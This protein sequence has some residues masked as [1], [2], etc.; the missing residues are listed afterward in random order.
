MKIN[1]NQIDLA[2][3][4]P[5]V[6]Q[7]TSGTAFSGNFGS[8][9]TNGGYMGPNVVWTSGGQ[10]IISG[11][12]TFDSSPRVPYSG[13][14][15][16]APSTLLVLDLISN[17]SGWATGAYS[18]AGL[19]GASGV[20]ATTIF[21]TGAALSKV[22]VTGS[23][24]IQA[25]N[26]TGLGGTLIFQ[27]G[28][29]VFI[30]GGAG[31][32]GGGSV[33]VTGSSAISSA[34]FTGVGSTSVTYNGT[35]VLI[36]GAAGADATLSG[37]VEN[38]FV[39]R[40]AIDESISGFKIFTGNPWVPAPTALSGVVNLAYLT[41]VSGVLVS[42]AGSI[43]NTYYITGTGVVSI[44]ASGTTINNTISVTSGNI[45][46]TNTGTNVTTSMTVTNGTIN[47]NIY[48]NSLTGNFVNMSWFFD[49]YSLATGLNQL[50][51]FVG[52]TFIFTG[53]AIGVINTGT[54][55]SFSGSFYQRNTINAKTN[56]VSFGLPIGQIFSGRGGFSQ[57][58]TGMNR[59]G[60]DIFSIGTGITGLT[61][62]LFGVGY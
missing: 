21:Q 37:F 41:G 31:G 29:F 23:S 46:M 62:G 1:A 49:E 8:Y 56:F 60:L 5:I 58:I 45:N 26:F 36:S 54:Q 20:L 16:T 50:E 13:N 55:G 38:N 9:V 40:G 22:Q 11:V 57:E 17:Y 14:T 52:R 4:T 35:Y 25:V 33:L 42:Q 19:L 43:S 7:I 39:H 32:G 24:T 18:S 27:S 2:T 44:S 3:L 47:S 51:S 34:N 6:Q 12:K 61:V 28:A 10:Q 15:G 59:V 48:A 53:Y 30:S